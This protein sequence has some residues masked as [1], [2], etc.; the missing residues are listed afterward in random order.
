MVVL[1]KR[2]RVLAIGMVFLGLLSI[3]TIRLWYVQIAAAEVNEERALA[4]RLREV[5]TE[6]PRGRI[7]DAGGQIIAETRASRTLLVDRRVLTLE[8]EEALVQNLSVLL[9]QPQDSLRA[10]FDQALSGSRFVVAI[11]VPGDVATQ[12]LEYGEEFPGVEVRLSPVRSY[13]EG[14]ETVSHIVGYLGKPSAD[15][16]EN[17]G[18][19]QSNDDF[20]RSG[21]EQ[22]YDNLLRGQRG[23]EIYQEDSAGR[24]AQLVAEEPPVGGWDAVLTIDLELQAVVEDAVLKAM[25]NAEGEEADPSG[26]AAVIVM[27]VTDGSVLSMVSTPTFDPS[28]FVGG[29]DTESFRELSDTGSLFN[30]T[31]QGLYPPAST[32]KVVPYVVAADNLIWPEGAFTA[33]TIIDLPARLIFGGELGEGS[34]QVFNDWTDDH[35]ETNLHSALEKSADA[36]FW[37]LAL[38]IWRSRAVVDPNIIQDMAEEL[39]FGTATGVDLPAEANGIVPDEEWISRSRPYVGGDLMNV[40]IGQGDLLATPLQVAN[41]FATLVNGGNVFRPRVVSHFVDQEGEVQFV[42]E[43]DLLREVDIDPETLRML[44]EDLG[45]VVSGER[46]TA[47]D[48]FRDSPIRDQIGGK[49]GTAEIPPV[50]DPV[51]T[52]WFVG[53]APLNNPKY[54]V[55]VMI[56]RGGSGS[57]TAAPVVRDILEHLMGVG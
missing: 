33:E 52:A 40:S 30:N 56:D 18:Y 13:F 25:A 47:R 55:T 22:R 6:A 49:S 45:R 21:I 50:D 9:N 28:L 3:L 26:K 38:E 32:F 39:G 7:L 10:N 43:P 41:S 48:A 8:Q 16:L 51:T 29:I 31:T 15:D 24:L 11:D 54:I 23:R 2:W 57:G 27:D 1:I 14:A 35:G 4:N 20:G 5:E 12:V 46:G 53:L 36:Y 42:N 17:F 44:T 37:L 34:Q 19:L